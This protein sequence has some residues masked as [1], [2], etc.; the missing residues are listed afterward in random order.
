M[1]RIRPAMVALIWL[2]VTATLAAAQ[3]LPPHSPGTICDTPRG[4]CWPMQ[5][6]TPGTECTCP[7]S[8]TNVSGTYN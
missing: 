5:S 1:S 8:G 3:G 6:G 7:V 2:S 4:W